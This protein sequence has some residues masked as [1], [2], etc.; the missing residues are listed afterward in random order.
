MVVQLCRKET[1]RGAGHLKGLE[2]HVFDMK[3]NVGQSQKVEYCNTVFHFSN[4]HVV[5]VRFI[6]V[7]NSICS[8]IVSVSRRHLCTCDLSGLWEV[9]RLWGMDLLFR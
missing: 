8:A 3:C 2:L 5:C 9:I 4:T 6:A 7:Y 1:R